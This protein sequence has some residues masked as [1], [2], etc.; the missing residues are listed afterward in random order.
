MWIVWLLIG[1]AAALA[2][3]SAATSAR[4]ARAFPPRGRFVEAAGAKIHY[5]EMAPAK[6]E[7]ATI[8]LIHG[9]SGNLGDMAASLMPP[10]AARHRVIAIDRPGHGW[11]ERP[12]LPGMTDPAMQAR[13][14]HEAL[15]KIGVTKPVLLGHSWGGAVATAYALEFPQALSGL[16]VL[17]GATHVW[18]GETAWYHRLVAMPVAGWL[19]LRTLLGPGGQLLM[20]PGVTGVFAP[21]KAPE[22]YAASIGLPLLFRPGHFRA[23]SA[24][25]SGLRGHLVSQSKRYSEIKVPTIIVTGNRDKTVWA[26]LHSYALHEEIAGSELIKL[27]GV[28]HMPHYVRPEIVID[29]LERLARGEPPRAGVHVVEPKAVV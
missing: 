14:I 12:D 29:A 7:G 11:S 26:K 20:G 22:G 13:V 24:D 15:E 10:L 21:D 19:F 5:F 18:E 1:L 2:L 23:N 6:P 27:A 4:I 28:G 16:L 8:V 17:S 9:A 25:S 3:Y